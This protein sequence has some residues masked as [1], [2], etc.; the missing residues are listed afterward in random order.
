ME[1]RSDFQGFESSERS[2]HEVSL[3]ILDSLRETEVDSD[4]QGCVHYDVRLAVIVPPHLS[5][6][7]MGRQSQGESSLPST[8]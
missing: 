4:W 5:P 6:L 3:T 7:P 2:D 1:R 8:F